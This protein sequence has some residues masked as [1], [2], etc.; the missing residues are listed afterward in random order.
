MSLAN[1]L[2]TQQ[3]SAFASAFVYNVSCTLV[4]AISAIDYQLMLERIFLRLLSIGTIQ[5]GR[6]A[7]RSSRTVILRKARIDLERL[8]ADQGKAL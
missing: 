2:S 5:E 3:A 4:F 7:I 8:K 1:L 6:S